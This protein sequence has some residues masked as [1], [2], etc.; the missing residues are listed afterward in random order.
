M[1]QWSKKVGRGLIAKELEKLPTNP[2]TLHWNRLE[3]LVE[4]IIVDTDDHLVG[5]I[6]GATSRTASGGYTPVSAMSGWLDR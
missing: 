5:I 6:S 2:S 3:Y 4:L 1:Q